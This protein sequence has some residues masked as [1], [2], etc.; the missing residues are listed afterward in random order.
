MK[1]NLLSDSSRVWESMIK[2]LALDRNFLD[3]ASYGR[4]QTEKESLRSGSNSLFDPVTVALV[5]SGR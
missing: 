5:H 2:G 3:V 4:K 1:R